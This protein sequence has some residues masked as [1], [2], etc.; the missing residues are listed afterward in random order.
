MKRFYKEV[1]V[2]EE[3]HIL[4][5]GKPVKTPQRAVLAL[6]TP[7]LAEA[8][9]KEWRAQGDEVLPHGMPLTKLANTAIDRVA[10]HEAEIV[11]QI[12]AYTN[13]LLC[14]RAEAPADLATR[15][16]AQWDP[17]LDWAAERYARLTVRSGV[18][19]IAQP[20]DA[21]AAYGKVLARFDR[22]RLTALHSAATLCGS[23]VL[24]LALA[25]GRLDAEE[26]FA[27]SQLDERY[28]AEKWG[29][30][31]DA[32]RRADAMAVE[33]D[34]AARFMRLVRG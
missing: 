31:E 18:M 13:D 32:K 29:V 8:V 23:L 15:Q 1:T 7:A 6:P 34:A 26:A 22:Y 5:D 25:E 17:L 24:A 19:H 11:T 33:L 9:A 30:D 14:Y 2:G 27:L 16:A 21:V 10:G 20:E 28:Q 3:F 4:L 12:L